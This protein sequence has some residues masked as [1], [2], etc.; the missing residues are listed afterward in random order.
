[1]KFWGRKS[2]EDLSAI[3][4]VNVRRLINEVNDSVSH[5]LSDYIK[6][7][8][9]EKDEGQAEH[10]VNE[11][12]DVLSKKG[13][14]DRHSTDSN[15]VKYR[16]RDLYGGRLKGA[17]AWLCGKIIRLFHFPSNTKEFKWYHGILMYRV[18]YLEMSQVEE[19]LYRRRCYEESEETDLLPIEYIGELMDLLDDNKDLL[20]PTYRF[21][22][23]YS[24]LEMDLH[25]KPVRSVEYITM[26]TI[27]DNK[28]ETHGSE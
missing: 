2:T 27:L 20:R 3:D 16:W 10:F 23:P 12:L 28:G 24:I 5:L 11:Y 15:I 26:T 6:T 25:F 17:Y 22:F 4:Q 21:Y 13:F 19:S 8:P 18:E 9:T 14:I 1:M 7:E